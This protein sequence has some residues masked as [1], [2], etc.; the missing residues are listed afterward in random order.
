[1]LLF[2]FLFFLLVIKHLIVGI[3]FLLEEKVKNII[4]WK[5]LKGSVNKKQQTMKLSEQCLNNNLKLNE[6]NYFVNELSFR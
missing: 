1:M 2:F 3:L 6:C 5:K 4:F